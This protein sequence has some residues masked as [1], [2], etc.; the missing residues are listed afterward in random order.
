MSPRGEVAA[1]LVR[2]HAAYQMQALPA[3]PLDPSTPI[4]SISITIYTRLFLATTRGTKSD[5]LENLHGPTQENPV[6]CGWPT[7]TAPGYVDLNIR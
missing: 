4:S 7:Q 5:Y 6:P 3:L 2:R 1:Y